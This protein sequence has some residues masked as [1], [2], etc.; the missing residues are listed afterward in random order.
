MKHSIFSAVKITCA[1]AKLL[2]PLFANLA[3][4][5]MTTQTMIISGK[6]GLLVPIVNPANLR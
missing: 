4:A 6:N 1:L 2:N 5:G 3:A